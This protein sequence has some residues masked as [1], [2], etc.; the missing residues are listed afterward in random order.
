[1][2]KHSACRSF[3]SIKSSVLLWYGWVTWKDN[4]W[5]AQLKHWSDWKCFMALCWCHLKLSP[6]RFSC[7]RVTRGNI[8]CRREEPMWKG[9][10]SLG[11]WHGEFST[12]LIL[13]VYL[14]NF[15]LSCQKSVV[16]MLQIQIQFEDIN[17][18]ECIDAQLLW[19]GVNWAQ[20]IC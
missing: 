18:V 3:Q 12:W 19:T 14:H 4:P 15:F 11:V 10:P 5:K 8:T 17:W 6:M 2:Q 20:L 16:K 7:F 13:I 1:M 9:Q